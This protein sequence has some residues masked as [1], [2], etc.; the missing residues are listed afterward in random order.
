LA[1]QEFSEAKAAG[2]I[3][4]LLEIYKGCCT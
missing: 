1:D 3:T 4:R 2:G